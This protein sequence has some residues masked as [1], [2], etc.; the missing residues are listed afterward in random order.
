MRRS[1]L[2]WLAVGLLVGGAAGAALCAVLLG[3][4]AD[5]VGAAPA[6][7]ATPD[8]A[9][10]R[11]LEAELAAL[12]DRDR[13]TRAA[14]RV[15]AAPTAPSEPSGAERPDQPAPAPPTLTDVVVVSSVD[16][17][18]RTWKSLVVGPQVASA[19]EW[20][21]RLRDAV[22]AGNA[23]AVAGLVQTA[24]GVDAGLDDLLRGIL[25]TPSEPAAVRLS[26]LQ[27]LTQR[28]ADGLE[29]LADEVLRDGA[30]SSEMRAAAI[31]AAE[32]AARNGAALPASVGALLYDGSVAAAEREA[33][34]RAALAA[35]PVGYDGVVAAWLDGTD[36]VARR[37][38]LSALAGS[39]DARLLP[40]MTS[41]VMRD[42]LRE[43]AQPL[44]D[45]VA[46]T[47]DNR[48]SAVQATGAPDTPYAGDVATAWAS[49]N[50]EMGR[51]T[52]ELRY[53]RA[54]VPA[55]VRIHETLNPGAV[56]RL[57]GRADDGA[58]RELW[59]GAAAAPVEKERWFAPP[60]AAGLAAVSEVRIELDTDAVTGWNEIDAVE[61]IGT[62][63]TRQWAE[64]ASASS[65]YSPSRSPTGRGPTGR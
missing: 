12:R 60:L 41:T 7:T 54:V 11:E 4:H 30:A 35:D 17:S 61:L 22:A 19:A 6:P 37:A 10:V 5:A 31:G 45:A 2:A 42:D 29:L 9:R 46:E 52:L 24:P 51:V 56:V 21:Q 34:L 53:A 1:A 59:Q 48:W 47:K 40:R 27:A 64:S 36:V 26:A 18:F 16:G 32:V 49:R 13:D 8:A 62:D 43:H 44:V 20:L 55:Q 57:L 58:W 14:S 25:R 28:G 23:G 38:A 3:A 65:A 50:A 33:A 63:G 39:R 15:R